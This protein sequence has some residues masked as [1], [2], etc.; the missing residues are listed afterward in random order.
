VFDS[1]IDAKNRAE[2]WAIHG[3]QDFR[4]D[5]NRKEEIRL[6]TNR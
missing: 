5:Q 6:L 1:Q 3:E 4:Q 2:N